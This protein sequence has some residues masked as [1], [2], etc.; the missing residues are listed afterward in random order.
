[1]QIRRSALV[2]SVILL[3]AAC[4]DSD[5]PASPETQTYSVSLTE[6]TVV[7]QGSDDVIVIDSLPAGGATLTSD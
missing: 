2:A 6:V 4:S 7:K 5:N 3:A 1:M